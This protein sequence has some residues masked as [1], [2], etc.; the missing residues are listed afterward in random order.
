[1][2]KRALTRLLEQ[3][4]QRKSTTRCTRTYYRQYGLP[5]KHMLR[6]REVAQEN[7]QVIDI[8]KQWYLF[9]D[10]AVVHSGQVCTAS[11]R[12]TEAVAEVKR[13]LLEGSDDEANYVFKHLGITRNQVPLP[14]LEPPKK[15]IR[16]T[17]AIAPRF[18][19]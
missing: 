2:S 19:S 4:N 13:A 11:R 3:W 12:L 6:N 5:C 18:N 7:L 16:S 10:D 14:D 1:M 9:P 17:K 15:R 8:H